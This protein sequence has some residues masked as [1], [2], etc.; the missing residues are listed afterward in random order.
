[1]V[2]HARAIT[3]FGLCLILLVLLLGFCERTRRSQQIWLFLFYVTLYLWIMQSTK[4]KEDHPYNSFRKQGPEGY[5]TTP[6]SIGDHEFATADF[7]VHLDWCCW[8]PTD[9]CFIR[10]NLSFISTM[11]TSYPVLYSL[12]R[13]IASFSTCY[14]VILDDTTMDLRY[15]RV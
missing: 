13:S 15:K 9:Q 3:C 7:L 8:G 10:T 1:L 4:N 2:S 6:I 11:L 5:S 12:V 14:L